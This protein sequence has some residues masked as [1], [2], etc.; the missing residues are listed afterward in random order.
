MIQVPDE[1]PITT[2]FD[3]GDPYDGGILQE[4]IDLPDGELEIGVGGS[5]DRNIIKAVSW[6]YNTDEILWTAVHWCYQHEVQDGVIV[7]VSKYE[8]SFR[9]E[10]N[11]L[12]RVAGLPLRESDTK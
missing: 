3:V 8:E 12:Y 7:G 4:E 5:N 1:N 2:E 10:L 6:D 9:Y 11:G